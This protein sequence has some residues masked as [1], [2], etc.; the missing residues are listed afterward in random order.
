MAWLTWKVDKN[1]KLV[2][3]GLERLRK[4]IPEIGRKRLYDAALDLRRR[5]AT[6]G[7][8]V[9]YPIKW[10][11]VKQRKAFFATDGFGA[12]IPTRRRGTYEKNW[13]VVPTQDGY[14]VGNPLAHAKHIGGT[15]RGARQSRIHQGRWN[16]FKRQAEIVFNKLPKTVRDNLAQIARNAG[17]KV[18][19]EGSGFPPKP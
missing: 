4:R 1:A 13:K 8:P 17:F 2:R 19:T 9:T 10:D 6:P 7:K 5:M 12:G 18:K 3:Q 14:D 11:S 15:P 16:L